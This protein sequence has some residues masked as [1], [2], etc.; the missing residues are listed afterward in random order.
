M[1]ERSRRFFENISESYM[2]ISRNGAMDMGKTIYD[3]AHEAG[4]SISTVSR[5]LNQSGYVSEKTRKKVENAAKGYVP[6]G[7]AIKEHKSVTIGLIIAHSP[8]YFFLNSN[9]TEVMH[10]VST[11]AQERDCYLLLDING[12]DEHTLKL[13]EHNKIDGLILMGVK[14]NSGL[15]EKLLEKKYPFVL[16]GDYQNDAN[17]FC[18]IEINDREMAKEATEHLLNFRHKRI[19]YISGSMEYASCMNR[20]LGYK[21][22]L[23]EANIEFNSEHVVFCEKVSEENV[24][25]IAKKLLYQN[26]RV[27]AILAFNDM[28]AVAT[29]KAAADLGLRIPEDLS[30]VGFDDRE[31]SRYVAPMLTTVWQPAFDKGYEAAKTLLNMLRDPDFIPEHIELK[32]I[33]KYRNSCAPSREPA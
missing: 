3:V 16:I 24:I 18:S 26:N 21:D 19:G 5:V 13:L 11:L 15:F 1:T 7:L 27:S 14:S 32:G 6:R 30:V 33:M 17:R 2:K 28:M 20:F 4:V 25:Q 12:K 9:Y 29:Y 31:I 22:A 23:A 8:S 10:G